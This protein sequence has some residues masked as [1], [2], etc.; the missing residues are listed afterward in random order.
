[1]SLPSSGQL[2]VSQ[3]RTEMGLSSTSPFSFHTAANNGYSVSINTL[4]P[5]HPPSGT[6][7]KISDWY[8]YNQS[9]TITTTTSTTTTTTPPYHTFALGYGTTA[10]NAC[11]NQYGPTYFY[12]YSSTLANGVYIYTNTACTTPAPSGYFYSDG[13]NSYYIAGGL[14]Q[15]NTQT[16]C[17]V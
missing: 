17:A 7:N 8:S 1:M 4:S 12:S 15:L 16:A 10:A 6:P 2:A 3:I 9:Y 14:G 11:N 13:G 5:S